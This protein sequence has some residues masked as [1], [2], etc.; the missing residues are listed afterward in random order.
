MYISYMSWPFCKLVFDYVLFGE[1]FRGGS[2][3]FADLRKIEGLNGIYIATQVVSSSRYLS[4]IN[5]ITLM[6]FNKGGDWHV[7]P[8][9]ERTRNG[10][11]TCGRTSTSSMPQV[12]TYEWSLFAS[13]WSACLTY[14]LLAH[15]E[16]C[17]VWSKYF[18][19]HC[20]VCLF[21]QLFDIV[22]V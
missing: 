8:A 18:G 12:S 17:C 7:I 14:C 19:I 15:M 22:Q 21:R 20:T 13:L 3:P 11:L 1:Y 5:Q 10:N 6:T 16:L 4:S 9:P 2:V